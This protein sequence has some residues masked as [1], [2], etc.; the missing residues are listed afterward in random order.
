LAIVVAA[1]LK[2][3]IFVVD[4]LTGI[5]VGGVWAAIT[6]RKLVGL[7]VGA[8][9]VSSVGSEFV[10]SD[11]DDVA[12]ASDTLTVRERVRLATGE[13]VGGIIVSNNPSK[14]QRHTKSARWL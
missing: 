5:V 14:A 11:S 4:A 13:L 9:W 1:G 12:D 2:I 10:V 8:T 3:G 6:S 7:S